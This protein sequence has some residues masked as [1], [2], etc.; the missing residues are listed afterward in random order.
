[1][2]FLRQCTHI[3]TFL[4]LADTFYLTG[5]FHV[6]ALFP[7]S[8]HLTPDFPLELSKYNAHMG[9]QELGSVFILEVC[10]QI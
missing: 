1:M 5:T 3:S 2:Y 8:L 9:S 10:H 4:K 6:V 7:S